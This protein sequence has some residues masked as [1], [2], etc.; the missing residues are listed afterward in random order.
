MEM[1]IDLRKVIEAEKNA[2]AAIDINK[3]I[4]I[5]NKSNIKPIDTE[6]AEDEE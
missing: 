1:N 2:W 5:I 3:L 4:E 6:E